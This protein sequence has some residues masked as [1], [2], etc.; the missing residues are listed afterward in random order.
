VRT[1]HGSVYIEPHALLFLYRVYGLEFLERTYHFYKHT[2]A[3]SPSIVYCNYLPAEVP[4]DNAGRALRSFTYQAIGQLA[5]RSPAL[6][7]S[8]VDIA[9]RCFKALASEPSGIRAAVQEAISTLA[10]AYEGCS[11]MVQHSPSHLW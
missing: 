5:A 3:T 10:V 2:K 4:L 9:V 7:R 8:R 11:G 1:L 6:V